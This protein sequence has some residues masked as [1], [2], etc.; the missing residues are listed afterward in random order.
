MKRIILALFIGATLNASA[1]CETSVTANDTTICPGDSVTLNAFGPANGLTTTLAGGNNHRGNM[2]DIV[3]L[4]TVTIESFDA[5]P[6][7]NTGYEIYYKVGGY[8]GSEANAA[9][10][11]LLG[12]APT[13]VA[14]PMGTPTPIPIPVN[15]TIP[16]GQT[17]AFYV[18]STNT[19]VAQ[20]YTDGSAVGAVFASDANIQ[21]L[22]GAGMEYPFTAGGSTF[23]PRVWNGIIHY[24]TGT[25]T[26]FLWGTGATT[27]EISV[28]PTIETTYLVDIT[29]NGCPTISDSVTIYM[30][31]VPT[32][33]LG[34]DT[35]I[36]AGTVLTLDAGPGQTSY[37]WNNGSATTQ[38]IDVGGTT[39]SVVEVTNAEGCTAA[40][41]IVVSESAL[42]I[43]SIGSD[44]SIC[45]GSL[46]TLDAGNP[47][48]TFSWSTAE[49][50]QTIDVGAGTYSVSVTSTEGCVDSS[51]IVV[52]ENP[53]PML[54]LAND[55]TICVNGAT[56]ID[57]GAGFS[58]YLWS[59]SETSQSITADGT[60]LGLGTH[61]IT[62]EVT[63]SLGCTNMDDVTITVDDCAGI[64]S[65]TLK[66][67]E[68]YPNPTSS[69]LNVSIDQLITDA[70]LTVYSMDGVRI[71]SKE[72]TSQTEEFDLSR[73]AVGSYILELKTTDYQEIIKIIKN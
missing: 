70:V 42:P 50:T 22:E 39:T 53:S 72:M 37:D 36:C 25:V 59:T 38:T 69:I 2:F 20:N 28:A 18:T 54:S 64:S 4:N 19:A 14:Q 8:A 45:E 65:E 24:S 66:Y 55:T 35:S 73:L 41:T 71:L 62:V 10:W 31:A 44:T 60:T 56:T 9:A 51:N 67:M 7:A 12:T 68:V 5:H 3:A 26:S 57:A 33:D 58:A 13:V 61:S 47:G 46:L 48:S 32:V 40:D 63:D 6:M 23:T 17:Y 16:A 52:T 1:Q 15:V 34:A 27:S 30:N 43:V 29:P 11:T 49:T 21:F